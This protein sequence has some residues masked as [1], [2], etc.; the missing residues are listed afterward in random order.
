MDRET[1]IITFDTADA[2]DANR[3]AEELRQALLD[4]SPDVEAYR[5]RNDPYTQDFGGTLVL[6]LGTPAAVAVAKAIGDWLALR[7]GTITIEAE[8]GEITKI[9]GTNLS[10]EAQLKVL[11]IMKKK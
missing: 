4:A 8:N 2:A 11:E 5:R 1:Y 7:R 10:S 9:T 6:L 3:H